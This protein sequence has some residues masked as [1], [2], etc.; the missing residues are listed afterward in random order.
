MG[1]KEPFVGYDPHMT[2]KTTI[3]TAALTVLVALS[4]PGPHPRLLA[5][6]SP[7]TQPAAQQ[8]VRVDPSLYSGMRWRGLGPNRGGRSIAVA[9]S[10]SRPHEYYFGTAGGGVWKTTDFGLTWSAVGDTDFDRPLQPRHRLRRH[11]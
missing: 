11:G 1:I 10:A 9:G 5:Q 8:G 6:A 3:T 2:L 7:S 4:F